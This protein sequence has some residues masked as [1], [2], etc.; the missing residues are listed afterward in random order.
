MVSVAQELHA[1]DYARTPPAGYPDNLTFIKPNKVNST[2][3]GPIT[4]RGKNMT[5]R[6]ITPFKERLLAQ[7]AELH[8]QL[9]TLRGGDI[10]RVEASANH[11][12]THE[13]STA[14]T[15][16]ARELEFALDARE[17]EELNQIEAALRRIEDGSYGQCVDCGVEIPSARLEVAP[18]AMR[19]IACQEKVE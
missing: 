12:G 11:F 17:T 7:R 8:D 5:I 16:T 1:P 2:H 14:Q 15:N 10:G 4:H 13:D 18:E 19:C 9:K 6:S 3:D